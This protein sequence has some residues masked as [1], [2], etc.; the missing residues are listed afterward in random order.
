MNRLY[1]SLTHKNIMLI[2]TSKGIISGTKYY[3]SMNQQYE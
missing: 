3:I 1:I 2:K